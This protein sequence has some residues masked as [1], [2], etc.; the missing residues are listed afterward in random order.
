M[1]SCR[2]LPNIRSLV[3]QPDMSKC[4]ANSSLLPCSLYKYSKPSGTQRAQSKPLICPAAGS[5]RAMAAVATSALVSSPS[6]AAALEGSPRSMTVSPIPL[7]RSH[8]LRPGSSSGRL[9]VRCGSEMSK[10]CPGR[11]VQNAGSCC[12]GHG[13]QTTWPACLTTIQCGCGLRNFVIPKHQHSYVD[14]SCVALLDRLTSCRPPKALS[15]S[16]KF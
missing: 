4:I 5:P 13:L 3:L 15:S 8:S 12:V 11:H 7:A 9:M 1:H 16:C 2:S 10:Q 14:W 6:A